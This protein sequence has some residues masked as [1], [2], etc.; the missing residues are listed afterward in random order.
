MM[1]LCPP[2]NV[3]SSFSVTT[4][5]VTLYYGFGIFCRL[6]YI[7]LLRSQYLVSIGGRFSL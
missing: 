7:A 1:F 4:H 5:F 3:V 6:Q 2:L